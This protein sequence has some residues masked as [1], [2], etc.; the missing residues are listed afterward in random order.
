MVKK[1]KKKLYPVIAF[2]VV[3]C[4]MILFE[5]FSFSFSAIYLILIGGVMGIVL[6]AVL[7]IEK[8]AKK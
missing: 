4:L 1:M 8:E 6:Y 3:L 7:G 5:L 2:S